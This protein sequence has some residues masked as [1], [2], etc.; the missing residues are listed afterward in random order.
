MRYLT[1]GLVGL[2]AGV[3]TV[4][5]AAENANT[6]EI[7]LAGLLGAGLAVAVTRRATS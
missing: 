4:S 6:L 1:S 2:A 3:V 7:V 5:F